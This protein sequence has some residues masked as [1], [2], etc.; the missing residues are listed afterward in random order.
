MTS[1]PARPRSKRQQTSCFVHTLLEEQR[2]EGHWTPTNDAEKALGR[3]ADK[4]SGTPPN[5]EGH[6]QSRL[7]TK[8]Q[9]S[10]MAFGIRELSKKLGHFR[11]KLKVRNVFM[12]TKAHDKT[13]IGYT[14]KMADWLLDRQ[15]ADG[16]SYTV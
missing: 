6:T 4:N 7:L 11:V 3:T 14:R 10:D 9:L 2:N 5:H 16:V 15:N 8:K 1:Q 12:L 13:L